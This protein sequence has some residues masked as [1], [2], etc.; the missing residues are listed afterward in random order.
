MKN[1]I[2]K[3]CL[4]E[5]GYPEKLHPFKEKPKTLYYIGNLPDPDRHTVAM[6]GARAC[7]N[8]GRKHAFNIARELSENGVQIIS[9]MARGIDTYS[10]LGALKG[11]TPTFAVL[12][13]GVDVC[14][15][16]ENIELYQ[17][18]I[19][20]GGGIISEYEPGE[21]AIGWHFPQRNRIISA[22]ADKVVII[23]A[24]EKS[25][26]FITVEWA[27]EQGKDVMALPGR[28]G[29]S[30]SDGCNRLIKNGAALVTCAADIIEEIGAKEKTIELCIKEELKCLYD[31]IEIQP[32]SI[33]QLMEDSGL[34]Y[35]EITERILK[36]QLLGLIEQ[37]SENY[38]ALKNI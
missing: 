13:C 4:G 10:A 15:P 17:D 35:Q 7:S 33:Y 3:V 12:G 23:E 20:S 6:I 29:E 30:L 25:G 9:G 26:S 34:T 27:L 37:T 36:L 24:K 18:I 5:E 38:F 14:Y 31:V 22:F 19:D 8:Y 32:R 28:V 2:K 11:G 21:K 1:Q 16:S